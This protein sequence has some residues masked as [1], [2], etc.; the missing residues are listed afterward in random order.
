MAVAAE[1]GTVV[2]CIVEGSSVGQIVAGVA[3]VL[4][5]VVVEHHIDFLEV[6]AA[7]CIL[8]VAVVG[9][10]VETSMEGFEC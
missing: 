9:K 6:V 2:D 8:P 4:R 7:Y 10:V 5:I 1:V 3:E